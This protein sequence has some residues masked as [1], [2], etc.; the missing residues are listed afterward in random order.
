MIAVLTV[1]MILYVWL[2]E[3]DMREIHSRLLN[4]E[5]EL[6]VLKEVANG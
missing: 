2:T 4:L 5:E 1:I 3:K 6:R